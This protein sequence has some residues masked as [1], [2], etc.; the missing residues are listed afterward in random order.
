MGGVLPFPR[1]S[2][3]SKPRLPLTLLLDEIGAT[4]WA[5]FLATGGGLLFF[6]NDGR[7]ADATESELVIGNG[8]GVGMLTGFR[9]NGIV[10]VVDEPVPP[11][12]VCRRG[13][14]GGGGPPLL[15]SANSSAICTLP[16]LAGN[17]DGSYG[18]GSFLGVELEADDDSSME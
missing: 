6:T 18:G 13:G 2:I 17:A 5:G 3:A 9:G 15:L 7:T 8:V 10:V 4:R 11:I 1:P 16:N 14:G 12:P